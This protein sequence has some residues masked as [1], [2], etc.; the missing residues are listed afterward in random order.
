MGKVSIS[1]QLLM[2][3]AG[4][5]LSPVFVLLLAWFIGWPR[6]RRLWSSRR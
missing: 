2:V 6:I 4:I 5:F 3:A 1:K